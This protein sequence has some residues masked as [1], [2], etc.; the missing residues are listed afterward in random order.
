MHVMRG[1]NGI[2]ILLKIPRYKGGN[3]MITLIVMTIYT[4]IIVS[5]IHHY[6]AKIKNM[7][8]SLDNTHYTNL[9][10]DR[11]NL[12]KTISDLDIANKLLQ[13]QVKQLK[14]S[15][16]DSRPFQYESSSYVNPYNNP[17][18]KQ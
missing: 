16:S 10:L 13:E 18:N 5:G 3:R 4:L 7:S 6:E 14:A 2:G 12:N 8:K 1:N 9:Q 11:H 15:L 17:L